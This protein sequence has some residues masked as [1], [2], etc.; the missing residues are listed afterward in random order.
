MKFK[1]KIGW[2]FHLTIL[3]IIVI[4]CVMPIAIGLRYDDMTS[5][6]IGIV[7][8]IVTASFI[9]PIYLNTHYTLEDD[10]LRIR[11]GYCI[12]KRIPYKD[13]TMIYETKNPSASAGLSF[14][15]ISVNCSKGEWLISPR[16]KQEFIRLL[17]QRIA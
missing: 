13:I 3:F 6:V 1:S 9:F 11:S 8:L 14:D 7:F 4:G 17:Q 12:N 10:T 2:W 5:L 15:R 16:N